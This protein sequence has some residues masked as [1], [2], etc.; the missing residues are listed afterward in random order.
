M[1]KIAIFTMGTRGDVQPYIFLSKE[2]IKSK[3][4][5]VDSIFS[6][7]EEINGSYEEKNNGTDK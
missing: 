5:S 1:G 4:L 6:A 2:P 3:D 7:I